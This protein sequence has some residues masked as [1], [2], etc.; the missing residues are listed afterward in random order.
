MKNERT[1]PFY[2]YISF[3]ILL[4]IALTVLLKV[5]IVTAEPPTKECRTLA[6]KFAEDPYQ[7]DINSL[8]TLRTCISNEIRERYRKTPP[9]QLKGPAPAPMPAPAP[10]K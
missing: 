3:Y 5:N 6:Q 8:A 7:L 2:L 1:V 10:S 4:I 9:P